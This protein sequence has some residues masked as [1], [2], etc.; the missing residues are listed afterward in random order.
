M[1]CDRLYTD[2][3]HL[4]YREPL[5]PPPILD[6]FCLSIFASSRFAATVYPLEML[7]RFFFVA[8]AYATPALAQAPDWPAA[9][10]EALDTL[11][12]LS[13]LDTSQPEGNEIL[14]ARYLKEKLDAEG[15]ESTIYEPEPGRASIVARLKGDGSRQPLLLLGHLDVVAVERHEWD[16]DPFGAEIKDGIIYARGTGDDKG[17]VAGSLQVFLEL[18]RKKVPLKRDVIFLGVADEE[19]G[20]TLGIT[21]LLD[22]HRE[23]IDAEFAINEGGGGLFDRDF[24][25]TRFSVQTAEKTPRRIDLNAK[26]TSG[27]GSRPTKDNPVGTLASAVARLFE[28]ETPVELN[29][30]TRTFFERLAENSPPE[31]AAVYR[32][33]LTGNPS[34]ETQDKLREINPGYYSMIR[35]SIVPTMIQGGY[36]KNVIPS[37]AKATVDIRALP[38]LDPEEFFPR[39]KRIMDEPLVD[40]TPH[41]VTRP[42]HDPSPLSSPVFQA[43][44]SALGKLYPET[45]IL[46]MMST[47]ATDSAQ[48]RAAGIESYG[49]GPGRPEWDPAS[50]VHGKNEYL[51]VRAFQ[52]YVEILWNVVHET[53]TD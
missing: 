5:L 22:N 10:Q 34:V 17:V 3:R 6:M 37:E 7:L 18:H 19:A 2:P 16:F 13:K 26:G 27:H 8:L 38:G 31:E 43:F 49:F 42:P 4:A 9:K 50:G 21:W 20:G 14:A 41:P 23:D 24:N 35:T 33:V 36:L 15:I 39:L 30:T 52:D 46:P 25:Y 11:I 51:Y 12:G 48:L 32:E 29:E 40:L 28:Y 44:E 1:A 53:V 45:V 47:G